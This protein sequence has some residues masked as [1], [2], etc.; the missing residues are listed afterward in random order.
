MDRWGPRFIVPIDG[1]ARL[2]DSDIRKMLPF[3][4]PLTAEPVEA[5]L[6]YVRDAGVEVGLTEIVSESLPVHGLIQVAQVARSGE[7]RS[8]VAGAR[9]WRRRR[10]V[11][12]GE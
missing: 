6:R 10:T 3:G 5:V 2:G 9:R 4:S 7:E 1:D 11:P 8:T 12:Y